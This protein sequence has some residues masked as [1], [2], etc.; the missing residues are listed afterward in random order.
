[1]INN[2]YLQVGCCVPICHLGKPEYNANEIIKLA[3]NL[4]EADIVIFPEM[5]ITGYSL[6][7][8]VN[9]EELLE[10]SLT[11]LNKIVNES[12]ESVWLVGGPLRYDGSLYNVCFVIQ[13]KKI[14]GIV[15]KMNLADYKEF[16][17]TRNYKS[18]KKLN[19]VETINL[20]GNDVLFGNIIFKHTL[21]SFGIE[22]GYDLWQNDAPHN[23]LYNE[24]AQVVF[25]LASSPYNV[26]K[27]SRELMLCDN[28]SFLSS[29]AYVFVSTGVTETTSDI[30]MTGHVAACECGE[31]LLNHVGLNSEEYFDYID[32]DLGKIN[33]KRVN[34][35][36]TKKGIFSVPYCLRLENNLLKKLNRPICTNPFSFKS[37]KDK[38][39]VIDV[40]SNSLYYRLKHIGINKVVLGVS[41]GLDS[42]LAL[43][44]INRCFEKHNL[45]KS[46][47]IACTM[48]GLGTG[49]KS[50]N[51]AFGLCDA[52][53]INL[54]E[55]DIKEEV[56][57]HFELIGK[58]DDKKDV[59]YENIQA[60]YRTLI[61]M[62]LANMHGGL[63]C[64]TGDMSEIALGWSTFNGDQM[65]MYNL[66]GGLPKT[67]IRELTAYFANLYP[68]AKDSIQGV[69]DLPISPELTGSNQ[70]TEDMI[71]KYEINDFLMYHVFNNGASRDKVASLIHLVF[72]LSIE[73]G[74]SYYDNFMKRFIRNQ[75][76][77]LT[78]PESVKIFEFSFGPRCDYKFPGDMKY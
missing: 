40:L 4:K 61:L 70:L 5:C 68:A 7:D 3:Y 46:G 19:K 24:G 32:I 31:V 73:E 77:R 15:P 33:H 65:S 39:E 43:L 67:I 72:N 58:N 69:I 55:I 9:N 47:I 60:R 49:S 57:H 13:N 25:N 59:T 53:G 20:F 16:N 2:N 1:M 11:A 18:G 48:P 27:I 35:K 10:K 41:G 51:N 37:D 75:F 26:G 50:K 17:E 71:G 54:R 52:L 38:E 63:V 23:S 66:N 45:D 12:N 36:N 42:T 8:W 29:G 14:L 21:C 78:G 34:K 56:M 74:Y 22:I 28:A 76:K 6:G 44:I 62:N 64:G 30:L